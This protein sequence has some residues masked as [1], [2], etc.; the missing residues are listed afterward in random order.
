MHDITLLHDCVTIHHNNGFASA[1]DGDTFAI[2]IADEG[3]RYSV[4]VKDVLAKGI[5]E[6]LTLL[7]GIDRIAI[8]VAG[9]VA[10]CLRY[11]SEDE[12]VFLAD[13][14]PMDS[15]IGNLC[16][17]D[18]VRVLSEHLTPQVDE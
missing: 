6:S 14:L 12:E 2:G 18:E 9:E 1:G 4:R 10:L 3:E 17:V 11:L 8:D 5:G 7:R 16:G 13:T 15:T